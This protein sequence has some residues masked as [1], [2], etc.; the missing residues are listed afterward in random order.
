MGVIY[1][2]TNLVNGKK[3][4]GRDG[5]NNPKY[6]GSGFLLKKAIKKEGKHNFKKEIIEECK[7]EHE[8]RIREEYWLNYYDA[9]NC[10]E[11]YNLRNSS[12]GFISEEIY[13]DKNPMYGRRHSTISKEKMSGKATGRRLSIDTKIKIGDHFRGLLVGEKNGFYGKTHSDE[14]KKRMSALRSGKNNPMYGVSGQKSPNFKG[15]IVCIFGKY[16]GQIKTRLEWCSLLEIKPQNFGK[17]LSGH[18]Y[19]N[20]IKGNFFKWE[21]EIK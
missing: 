11:F 17:H 5:N 6:L 9:A 20:G 21:H 1:M 18:K 12:A 4:I 14:S 19:K 13:G 8:L 16:K 3:Y 10:D 15:F 2:T 7:S